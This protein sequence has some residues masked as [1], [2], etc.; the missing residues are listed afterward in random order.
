[1]G[2]LQMMLGWWLLAASL[3]AGGCTAFAD[4]VDGGRKDDG[5]GGTFDGGVGLIIEPVEL[6]RQ[7]Q[8]RNYTIRFSEPPPWA[9]KVVD[10]ADCY[11]IRV[12]FVRLND[13]T[14]E[15]FDIETIVDYCSVEAPDPEILLALMQADIDA[16]TETPRLLVVEVAFDETGKP[17][18][19]WK[20]SAR[21]YVSPQN[22]VQD[23]DG[24]PDG[25]D[26]GG[27]GP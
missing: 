17:Q 4:A 15:M 11:K 5:D 22:D 25:G 7:G 18:Q 3:A 12:D 10:L 2:R 1:M 23:T 24:G 19:I 6:I 8:K 14:S 20:G 27:D 9:D 16:D 13:P 26:G 21:F